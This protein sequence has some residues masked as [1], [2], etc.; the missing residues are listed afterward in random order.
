M[1][2]LILFLTVT[3]SCLSFTVEQND[4]FQTI[5]M[6]PQIVDIKPSLNVRKCNNKMY[7]PIALPQHAKG[8]IYSVTA[9]SKQEVNS[10]KA[11][12]LDQLLNLSHKYNP[13]KAVDFIPASKK[14]KEFNL[15]ILQGKENAESFYNCNCY[16]YDEKHIRT[17]SRSGY[18]P[19]TGEATY[20]LGIERDNDWKNLRLKVEAVAVL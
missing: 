9:I 11:V 2:N 5:F 1:K 7:I 18:I 14:P 15:Y 19:A 16:K 13:T 4:P 20:Y 8:W 3:L 12:L 17:K 6:T 10:P